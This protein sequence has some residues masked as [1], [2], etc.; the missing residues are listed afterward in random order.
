MPGN[1]RE[2][3]S[4]IVDPTSITEVVSPNLHKLLPQIQQKFIRLRKAQR[5]LEL[6][7]FVKPEIEKGRP[8]IVFGNKAATTDYIS[9]FLND[10]GVKAVS[11]NGSMSHKIRV[12]QLFKFQSGD[13]N[14]IATTDVSSRGLDTTRVSDTKIIHHLSIN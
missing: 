10:N 8:I 11:L 12:N 14:V 6:L 3:V 4:Q 1:T 2:L 13:A 5:P 9:M 7:S